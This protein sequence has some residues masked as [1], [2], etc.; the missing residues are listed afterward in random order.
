MHP[1]APM[2]APHQAREDAC[3]DGYNILAGTT[4]F[5][6]VW[7][8]GRD[9]ALWDVPEEFRPERFLESKIDMRG[10]DFELLPFGSGRRMCPGYGLALKVMLL[11]LANLLHGF[12]W[13][14]PEGVTVEELS[15]EETFLLAVPR[16]FP[17]A[18]TGEPR[19]PAR[20]YMGAS[21]P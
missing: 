6:N 2:L 17:L 7:G 9:P 21:R 12:V 11:G 4:V 20:L 15:M 3:V 19:L 14:L 10:Q 18:A 5:I 1:A 16:K 13:R 8:I